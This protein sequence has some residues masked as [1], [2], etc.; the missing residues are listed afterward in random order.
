MAVY[1]QMGHHTENLVDHPELAA[2]EGAILSPVNY[3]EDEIALQIR[4][5]REAGSRRV[6]LDPQ[7]Y[8]PRTERGKLRE[9]EY[10]P[11][12]V[13]TADMSSEAWWKAVV[14]AFA[15]T[16][17]SLEPH[18]ACSPAFRPQVFANEYFDLMLAV[19]AEF[20]DA[21]REAE[22]EPIQT[23]LA[24]LADLT[25]P[26]RPFEIASIV[27]RTPCTWIYL[28]LIGD[29]APRRELADV[30]QLKGALRLIAALEDAGLRVIVGFSSSDLVLWKA[31]GASICATGK[32]FNLRRFTQ[33]RWEEPGQGGGQLPY[34]FEE[35]L[36]AFVRESDLIR[37]RDAN[38]LSPV[39]ESNPFAVEI[40]R[41]IRDEPGSPWLAL[42]W[43]QYMY[44]FADLEARIALH[45]VD[46]DELLRGAE[47]SWR[48]LEDRRPP[49]LMEEIRNDGSWLRARRRALLELGESQATGNGI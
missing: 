8:F 3:G 11:A 12:D 14:R 6:M 34:W 49:I 23:V 18:G 5:A 2:Y 48:A 40:L 32:F 44:A 10:F 27:S 42:S 13:D 33:S 28:V 15:S 17:R 30:E 35:S 20:H 24:G 1:H 41:T 26:T 43:R 19:G 39:H 37:L 9:W 22:I 25:S 21:V 47:N 4:K 31:A 45:Q 36:M 46:I 16:C 29:T 38:L 7:L